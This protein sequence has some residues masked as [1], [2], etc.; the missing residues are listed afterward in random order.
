MRAIAISCLLAVTTAA[1][2]DTDT[3]EAPKSEDTAFWLSAGGTLG[4]VGLIGLGAAVSAVFPADADNPPRLAKVPLHNWGNGIAAAG[5]LATGLAPS[6]GQWYSHDFWTAGLGLRMAGVVV[7][8]VGAASATCVD[9][10]DLDCSSSHGTAD[11]LVVI[12]AVTYGAGVIYDIATA[13]RAAREY[14]QKHAGAM[15]LAPTAMV[16]GYGLVLA[17]SF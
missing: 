9:A 8:G 3:P 12:G 11:T 2:A 1:H 15:T 4:A 14:N 5:V 17:G 16:H 13:R 10:A 6:L 7:M